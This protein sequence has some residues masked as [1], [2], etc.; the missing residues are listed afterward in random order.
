MIMPSLCSADNHGSHC[1]AS[2]TCWEQTTSLGNTGN[3]LPVFCQ[4]G[5]P[6]L[7]WNSSS[8]LMIFQTLE[9][10]QNPLSFVKHFP[11]N[12]KTHTYYKGHLIHMFFIILPLNHQK[13]GDA[14]PV[15]C[16]GNF[17]SIIWKLKNLAFM[18]KNR[19]LCFSKSTLPL[20][21]K[22]VKALSRILNSQGLKGS[23]PAW[24]KPIPSFFSESWMGVPS[25]AHSGCR[26]WPFNI[27]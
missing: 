6:D 15:W 17:M 14:R 18:E 9:A 19:K 8:A 24:L 7:V 5:E 22:D 11:Q 4:I 12:L 13:Y 3:W 1:Q 20:T 10:A 27:K 25:M 21:Q 26:N 23:E 2:F 16:L